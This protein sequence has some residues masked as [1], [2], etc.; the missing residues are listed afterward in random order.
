[1]GAPPVDE[2]VE[3]P[4]EAARRAA[5]LHE[6]ALR[7]PLATRTVQLLI[8]S[9][10][11]HLIEQLMLPVDREGVAYICVGTVCSE[12]VESPEELQGAITHALAAP[13]F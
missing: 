10:D 4:R 1:M 8:P 6:R 2:T 9:R 7:L 3:A 12:P 13:T 11:D 5:A